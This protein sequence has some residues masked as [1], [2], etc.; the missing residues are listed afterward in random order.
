MLGAEVPDFS[1]IC[2]IVF[3]VIDSIKS[4]KST[5]RILGID[6]GL[7]ITGYAVIEENGSSHSLIEAG[8][9]RPK[10]SDQT[11][12]RLAEIAR[13]VETVITDL[14]P[15]A[16]AVEDLYSHYDHPK[17][18]IIMGH[19]RGVVL[20]KAAESNLPVY[21]YASTRIKN[22]LT[23]N[24]RASKRQ[25]QMMISSEFNLAAPPEPPDIADAMAV[26]LCHLRAIKQEAM[27]AK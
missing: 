6:P 1:P 13:E 11:A 22:S 17:T 24:G 4:Y 5:M 9:I 3:V 8:C 2:D 19:A 14:K 16:V 23:G 15:D 18:A 25:M 10:K 26:A 20:L 7:Q 21:I 27:T 12:I